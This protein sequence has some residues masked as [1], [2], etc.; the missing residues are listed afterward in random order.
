[1]TK[2]SR[3][4]HSL[5]ELKQRRQQLAQRNRLMR[6]YYR[7]QSRQRAVRPST[8][9]GAGIFGALCYYIAASSSASSPGRGVIA[10]ETRHILLDLL[11]RQCD[12]WLSRFIRSTA[13]SMQHNTAVRNRH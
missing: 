5:A 7:E 9:L 8:L 10:T 11:D 13:K 3:L 12:R 1:M 2:E 4:R 6:H